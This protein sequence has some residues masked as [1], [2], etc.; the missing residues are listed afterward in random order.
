MER[1]TFYVTLDQAMMG[2]S[3]VKTEDN[4]IQYEIRVTE[5]EK[6]ELEQLLGRIEGEDM[7]AQEILIRPFN[8]EAA[9][10]DKEETSGDIQKL[11]SYLYDFGTE[12]TR[13]FLEQLREQS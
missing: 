3:E 9:D 2:I 5:N 1:K 13:S 8:E 11:Y 7:E 12:R 4:K 6:E 10:E